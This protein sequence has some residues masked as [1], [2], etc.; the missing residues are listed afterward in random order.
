MTEQPA[1]GPSEPPVRLPVWPV[2]IGVTV[3]GAVVDLF[4]LLLLPVRLGGHLVPAGPLLVLVAN[5]VLGSIGNWLTG[6][7]VPARVLLVVAILL[8]VLG[9]SRGPGGDLLVTRDLQGMY[10]LF[11]LTSCLGAA[12]PLFRRPPAR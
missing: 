1:P 6:D 5:A 3:V 2:A 9:A 7:Q 11:V 4:C 12:I 10:L 8:A